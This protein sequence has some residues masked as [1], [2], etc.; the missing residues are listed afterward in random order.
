MTES[1]WRQ[2]DW[3]DARATSANKTKIRKARPLIGVIFEFFPGR[4]STLF[5]DEHR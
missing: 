5:G 2:G 4:R 3:C 1:K